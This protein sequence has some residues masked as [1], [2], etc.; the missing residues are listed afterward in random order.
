VR[1]NRLARVT[2]GGKIGD[3]LSQAEGEKRG[4]ASVQLPRETKRGGEEADQPT[5]AAV[6]IC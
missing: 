1:A 5:S 2:K 4:T 3:Y 6:D